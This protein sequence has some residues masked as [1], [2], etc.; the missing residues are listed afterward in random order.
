MKLTF[1]QCMSDDIHTLRDFSYR[2]YN[3]TFAHMNTPSNIQAYLEQS[4]NITKLNDELS[5]SNSL[6]YFLYADGE[7]AGYL[8]LNESP[9]QTDIN[10]IQSLEIERIYVSIEFQGKGLGDVLMNKAID[11]ANMRKK[12]YVWLGV[13]E[14]ND[15][16]IMFYKKNGFYEVGIHSFFMGEEEQTDFL[17]R[18]NL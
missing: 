3:E 8:K 5:D 12:L 7:L 1:K 9:A 16:A 11:I 13:W 4:F 18:K 17:M 14:K 10:D 6:F 15:K 2:T